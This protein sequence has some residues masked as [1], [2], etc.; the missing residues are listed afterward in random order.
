MLY[1]PGTTTTNNE[2]TNYVLTNFPNPYNTQTT[3]IYTIPRTS[4]FVTFE[5]YDAVGRKLFTQNLGSQIAGE[6]QLQYS[7]PLAPGE[8]YYTITTNNFKG[9]RKMVVVNK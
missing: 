8:Y 9:T 4:S 1:K 5:V 3:I 6:H 7:Q 2:E